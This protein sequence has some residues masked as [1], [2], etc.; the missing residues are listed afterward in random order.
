MPRLDVVFDLGISFNVD[1][2]WTSWTRILK[3]FQQLW[4]NLILVGPG[5]GSIGNFT[6][7]SFRAY[8]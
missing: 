4:S 5:T 7:P 8:V 1:S 3:F 6:S 2:S